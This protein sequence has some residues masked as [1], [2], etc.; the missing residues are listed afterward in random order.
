MSPPDSY[1]DTNR[2]FE[3]GDAKKQVLTMTSCVRSPF[4]SNRS[5]HQRCFLLPNLRALWGHFPIQ[6]DVLPPR[7]RH[8]IFVVDRLHRALG[9]A[10]TAVNAFIR[11]DEQHRL[12]FIKA[13]RRT[14]NDTISVL[15]A[16]TRFCH[17]HGHHDSPGVAISG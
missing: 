5:T 9:N 17:N 1:L 3:R 12:P 6:V 14:H 8:I 2:R 15:A 16:E 4:L 13:L 7:L 10:R 11:V